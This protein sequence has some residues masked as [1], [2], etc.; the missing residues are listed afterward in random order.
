VPVAPPANPPWEEGEGEKG[1]GVAVYVL[2]LALL[3]VD[4]MPDVV[5]T[6]DG[7]RVDVGAA[8]EDVWPD[9][10]LVVVEEDAANGRFDVVLDAGAEL[11]VVLVFVIVF[12][13]EMAP[14]VVGEVLAFVAV[15]VVLATEVVVLVV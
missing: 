4:E 6:V 13:V 12:D 14:V 1:D 15:V 2:V 11:V 3:V 5:V 10:I 9:K 8:D 7:A